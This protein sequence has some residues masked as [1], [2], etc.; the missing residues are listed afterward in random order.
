MKRRV[1][2]IV[3]D[4]FGI[5]ASPDAGDFGDEGASTLAAVAGSS[6]L[7]IPALC[8][9]GLF[10]IDGLSRRKPAVPPEGCFARLQ[11]VSQGKDTTIGHWEI[12]GIE[13]PQAFPTYPN[14]FPEEII[15]PFEKQTERRVLCNL[16]YSGTRVLEDYGEEQMRTGG[17]IV[18]TSADSVFQVAAHEDVVPVE[19]LYHCCRIAR[20]LLRGEHNVG[21][22]IARPFTGT[23]AAD[24]RRTARRHDFSRAP[25]SPTMLDYINE[26]GLS[27]ISVGKIGD[28]FAG[29]CVGEYIRTT[30]N[31]NGMETVSELAGRD[32]EGLV[33]INLVDFDMVYGHRR[34]VD[35]YAAALT[36]FDRWLSHFLKQLRKDDLL[37][38]TADHG[39]DPSYR[40]TTDHTREYVPLLIWG[41]PVRRG[42]NLGT[43]LSFSCI[44]QTVCDYLQVPCKLAGRS[45]LPEI[46]R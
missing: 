35:G 31:T 44:A 4:S 5:G 6:R 40:K 27:V 22:V 34:D 32:F 38:I 26:R 24:F 25:A 14:G 2:L 13:S 42:V 45:L 43:R 15:R 7:D 33:F 11:E 46:A 3:L 19:E 28:I 30:G 10:H 39:C 9:L 1:F 41:Q 36:E 17:L 16:P 8:R 37:M 12:A 21:R 23:C 18:Y 29:R 20:E